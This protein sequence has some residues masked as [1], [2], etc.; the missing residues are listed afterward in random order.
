MQVGYLEKGH[1]GQKEQ[2]GKGPEGLHR[3]CWRHNKKVREAQVE[4]MRENV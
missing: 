1:A 3:M 4:K 2:E